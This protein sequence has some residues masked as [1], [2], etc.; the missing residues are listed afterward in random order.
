MIT[1]QVGNQCKLNHSV[2]ISVNVF[3][4]RGP[5]H[6]HT[7]FKLFPFHIPS[8]VFLAVSTCNCFNLLRVHQ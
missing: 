4:Y 1:V 2:I 8:T 6:A 3:S 5:V 7:E